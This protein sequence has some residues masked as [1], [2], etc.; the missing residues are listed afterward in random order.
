MMKVSVCVPVF[1]KSRSKLNDR[2]LQRADSPSLSSA[3]VISPLALPPAGVQKPRAPPLGSIWPS[4]IPRETQDAQWD[5]GPRRRPETP[6]GATMRFLNNR[7]ESHLS[8]QVECELERVGTGA[9]VNQGFCGTPPPLPR[10]VSTIYDP[11]PLYPSLGPMDGVRAMPDP[12]PLNSFKAQPEVPDG[13]SSKKRRGC[14]SFVKGKRTP[15]IFQ[16]TCEE[17]NIKLIT[18]N[19]Y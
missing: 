2:N 12:G 6:R 11:Q 14:C 7:S 4:P 1:H 10:V 17:S 9:W 3:Y 8:G 13:R 19:H 5:P 18:N 15:S 16:S